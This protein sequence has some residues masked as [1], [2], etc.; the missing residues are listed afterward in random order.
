VRTNPSPKESLPSF[1]ADLSSQISVEVF[2]EPCELACVHGPSEQVIV[3][4]QELKREDLKVEQALGSTHHTDDD[5]VQLR[6]RS[7]QEATLEGPARHFHESPAVRDVPWLSC[8]RF[9]RRKF[10]VTSAPRARRA[11]LD[12]KLV[13][14]PSLFF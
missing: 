8:H 5:F 12:G 13:E 9:N 4:R 7:K 11:H 1:P 14:E 2:H 6:G 3:V 10:P